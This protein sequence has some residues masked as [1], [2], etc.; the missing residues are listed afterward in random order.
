MAE[1]TRVVVGDDDPAVR[2]CL[3]KWLTQ[4]GYDVRA[5]GGGGPEADVTCCELCG[6]VGRRSTGVPPGD[7]T[8]AEVCGPG[9][10]RRGRPSSPGAGPS[11]GPAV[12]G[13][14]SV[15]STLCCARRASVAAA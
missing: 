2:E 11:W 13:R 6:M 12:A 1:K 15:C 7:G 5:V 8:S 3:K 10:A 4:L 14:S 9:W